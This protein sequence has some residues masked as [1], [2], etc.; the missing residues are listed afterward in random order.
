MIE[1]KALIK[2]VK[3]KDFKEIDKEIINNIEDL[4]SKN[5]RLFIL[6]NKPIFDLQEVYLGHEYINQSW[7]QIRII[8]YDN[9]YGLFDEDG[10]YFDYLNGRFPQR[11]DLFFANK[12][13]MTK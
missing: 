13:I 12:K 8:N 11:K 6:L 2:I 9:K 1:S 7:E 10:T 3:A 4:E 5:N